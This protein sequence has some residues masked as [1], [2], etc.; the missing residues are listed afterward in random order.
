MQKN[1]QAYLS[2]EIRLEYRKLLSIGKADRE[3]ENLIISHYSKSSS[4]NACA[5]YLFWLTFAEV[6]WEMG[7]LSPYVREQALK[8][9]DVAGK[10]AFA[11]EIAKKLSSPELERKKVARP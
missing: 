10:E 9:L 8:S 1:T 4:T 7:R 6:Q 5:D 11:Q 2:N 3:A